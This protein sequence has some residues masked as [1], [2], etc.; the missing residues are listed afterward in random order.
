MS[1]LSSH[2]RLL[3]AGVVLAVSAGGIALAPNLLDHG[4]YAEPP[5]QQAPQAV[6]VSVATV[7]QRDTAIWSEF[8]GRLE[9]VERV[10]VRPRVSGQIQAV[11]F[12]E[13]EL[14]KQGD[15]LITI[16]PAPF[17]AAVAGAEAQVAAAEARVALAKNDLDRANQL[18][19]RV[20]SGRDLDQRTNAYREAEANLRAAKASLE[21]SRLN[22]SY[23]EVQAPVSGRV[24][25]LEVTVGNLVGEG[26]TAPVLTTLVSVDPI[27][28]SFNADE[29]VVLNA[30]KALGGGLQANAQVARIPVRMKTIASEGTGTPGQL[31]FIDNHV[32][33]KSGTVRV[34]ARFPNPD[35]VLIP[36]Q[37]ARLSMGQPKNEPAVAIDERA[38]GTD[39]DKKFVLVVD[40]ENKA[41]YREIEL[42]PVAEGMRIVTAGLKP[43]ERI[44]VNGLQRVRPGALV[45]PQMVSMDGKPAQ[46]AHNESTGSVAQR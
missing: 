18:S 5:A 30:L 23:T 46:Q 34:R 2:K 36:G 31:Q 16:D 1:F 21:S 40:A 15:K 33:A 25:K 42:G 37:F 24:G 22:L 3:S 43:G 38:I 41:V 10:D 12:R 35:G 14:V 4:A 29:T 20:L 44:V 6:P 27:Y 28:G 11:H 7:E 26:P 45:A 8:S 32:D 19:E 39:Q 9:A 17:A 13:G